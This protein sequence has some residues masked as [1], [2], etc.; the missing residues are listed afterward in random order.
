MKKVRLCKIIIVKGT[1]MENKTR[2]GGLKDPKNRNPNGR[3]QVMTKAKISWVR[4]QISMG[5]KQYILAQ[6]LGINTATL[7]Q[8]LNGHRI[9]K[10]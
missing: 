1:I 10:D 2:K 7:S 9:P 3:P 5:Y 4:E 8:Y 6:K